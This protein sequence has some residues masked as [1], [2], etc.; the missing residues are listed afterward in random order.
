MLGLMSG[1]PCSSR[2]RRIS[3]SSA[4]TWSRMY[5]TWGPKDRT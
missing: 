4:R 1:R 3:C 5:T 2:R